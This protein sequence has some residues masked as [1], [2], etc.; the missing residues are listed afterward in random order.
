MRIIQGFP[1]GPVMKTHLPMQEA[2]D[3]KLSLW[4]WKIP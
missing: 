2:G 3:A 1:D 4:V